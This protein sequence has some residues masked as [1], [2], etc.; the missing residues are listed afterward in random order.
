VTEGQSALV[1]RVPE[2]EAVVSGW[3]QRYD[4]IAAFGVPAHITVLAPWLTFSDVTAEDRKA[5]GSICSRSGP[6]DVTFTR[7]GIFPRTLW[8]DPQPAEPIRQLTAAVYA[9]WPSHPPYGGAFDDSVPHLTIADQRDP[10]EL[11]H[12]MPA[13]E[14]ALP[15]RAHIAEL[16]LLVLRDGRWVL[17]ATFP[18]G[19][20]EPGH[21]AS[22]G[23]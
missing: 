20:A 11:G 6:I 7:F 2:V 4:P 1:L 12:V 10:A 13:V 5:L 8:L 21:P 3:R 14:S 18:F 16:S 17:D 19:R 22:S 23:A 9:R 15:L